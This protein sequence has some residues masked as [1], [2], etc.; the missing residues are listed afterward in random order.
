M[1]GQITQALK[2]L[3]TLR[4]CELTTIPAA[5]LLESL[6]I[7]AVPPPQ[8]RRGCDH[9]APLIEA[10]LYLAQT[11]GPDTVDQDPGAISGR[12]LVMSP[13]DPHLMPAV[14]I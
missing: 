6:W 3:G 12:R 7:M 2:S 11:P 13:R 8:P 5:E 4:L 10:G 9:L 1:P 14:M